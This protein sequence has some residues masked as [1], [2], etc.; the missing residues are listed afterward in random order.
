MHLSGIKHS[1]MPLAAE[2]FSSPSSAPTSYCQTLFSVL[3]VCP[4][5]T[6]SVQCAGH[7]VWESHSQLKSLQDF[8]KR[9]KKKK[10]GKGIAFQNSPTVCTTTGTK[11][12]Q[13]NDLE[14]HWKNLLYY[15]SLM[16]WVGS[17][18]EHITK[19][20]EKKWLMGTFSHSQNKERFLTKRI[21]LSGGFSRF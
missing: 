6:V 13:I 9:K 17:S 15:D 11:T 2:S 12:L 1:H 16:A 14:V 19:P 4:Y 21:I 8:K 10:I 3:C 7:I 18:T 20:Q 5:F